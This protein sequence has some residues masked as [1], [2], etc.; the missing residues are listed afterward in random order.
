M[1]RQ[2]L[3]GGFLLLAAILIGIGAIARHIQLDSPFEPPARV[4]DSMTPHL[5]LAG[6]VLA[7]LAIAAGARITGAV[8][9][10]AGVVAAG[11]FATDHV[12]RS[13]PLVAP[14]PD[15]LRVVFFNALTSDDI[16]RARLVAAAIEAADPDVAIIAEGKMMSPLMPELR[17]HYPYQVGCNPDCEIV[18]LSRILLTTS[19]IRSM[20][21]LKKNRYTRLVL[22][23]P[24]KVGQWGE[25][26]LIAAHISKPWITGVVDVE[27]GQ[28]ARWLNLI[29]QPLIL[30]GDFNS[31]PWSY[32]LR[33]LIGWTGIRALRWPVATWPVPARRFGVPI[34]NVFVRG[35]ARIV[36]IQPFGDDLGSNHRGFLLRIRPPFA[37]GQPAG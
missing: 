35:G 4:F 2:R 29:R 25:L 27:L 19:E 12:E 30:V 3:I 11:V 31:A 33:N 22:D 21:A 7:L 8:V 32:G 26:D 9:L 34:D 10:V 14:G 13:L 15:D 37:P 1:I 16:A 6:I 5:L 23:L 28:L 17:A 20:G 18:V 24:Q 36:A